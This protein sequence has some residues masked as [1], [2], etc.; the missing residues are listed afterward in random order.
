MTIIHYVDGVIIKMTYQLF[1]N[2]SPA[3]FILSTKEV[4][5]LSTTPFEFNDLD[6]STSFKPVQSQSKYKMRRVM[7]SNRTGIDNQE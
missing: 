2:P 3:A 7:G 4:F 1:T 6:L 5:S